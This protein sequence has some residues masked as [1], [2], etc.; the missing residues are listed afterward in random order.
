MYNILD[1]LH[2]MR[3]QELSRRIPAHVDGIAVYTEH[4]L[5][6]MH[7]YVLDNEH[8][9]ELGEL[10]EAFLAELERVPA[11]TEIPADI[12]QFYN[13]VNEELADELEEEAQK[14]EDIDAASSLEDLALSYPY[15]PN[16]NAARMRRLLCS[17]ARR[18]NAGVNKYKKVRFARA[19][20]LG[21]CSA[22]R[23][24]AETQSSG[25]FTQHAAS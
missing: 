5:E 24:L 10:D 11:N 1:G 3:A 16:D 2:D 23:K 4:D 12:T 25:R 7:Q 18:T 21:S 9:L 20:F 22:L 17:H 13:T 15:G 8:N 19:E 6:H 14:N